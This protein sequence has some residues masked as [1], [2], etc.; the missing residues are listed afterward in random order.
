MLLTAGL[1]LVGQGKKSARHRRLVAGSE[2]RIACDSRGN[3]NSRFSPQH[4]D[5]HR[6]DG[7]VKVKQKKNEQDRKAVTLGCID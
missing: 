4:Q 3:C 2:R 6:R 7:S 1:I 5:T